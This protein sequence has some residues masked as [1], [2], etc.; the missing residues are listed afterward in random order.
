MHNFE[1]GTLNVKMKRENS[2]SNLEFIIL[3]QAVDGYVL[4]NA[5]GKSIYGCEMFRSP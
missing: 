1:R 2:L 3:C 5:F 4:C